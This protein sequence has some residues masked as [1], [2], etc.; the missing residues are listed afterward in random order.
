[1]DFW[2]IED[3]QLLQVI[4]EGLQMQLLVKNHNIYGSIEFFS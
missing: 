3:Q 4:F 1:M 2:V